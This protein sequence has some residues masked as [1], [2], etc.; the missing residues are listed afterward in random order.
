MHGNEFIKIQTQRG[1]NKL[2]VDKADGGET[3]NFW[4]GG[5]KHNLWS[6]FEKNLEKIQEK[7]Q[8]GA[9]KRRRNNGHS[10]GL[11]NADRVVEERGAGAYGVPKVTDRI[12]KH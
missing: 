5:E 6:E 9:K 12:H 11:A 4:L 3:H 2:T 10:G 7:I 1:W 8:N